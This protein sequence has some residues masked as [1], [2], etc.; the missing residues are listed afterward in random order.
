MCT[1][2]KVKAKKEKKNID[3]NKLLIKNKA[4]KMISIGV[5]VVLVSIILTNVI[6]VD[7]LYK[8]IGIMILASFGS[9]VFIAGI[10]SINLEFFG[11]IDYAEKRFKNII[12]ED[13]YVQNLSR[14]KLEELQIKIEEQKLYGTNKP[15][16]GSFHSIVRNDIEPM[17]EEIFLKDHSVVIDCD[18]DGDLIKKD[19]HMTMSH[20]CLDICKNRNII[21]GESKC[22]CSLS[23]IDGLDDNKLFKLKSVK[24]NGLEMVNNVVVTIEE[25]DEEVYNRAVHLDISK[26]SE[27][28]F[29]SPEKENVFEIR[30]ST[31]VPLED[32]MVT[33]RVP[34]PAK[35][36][37][38][39][40]NYDDNVFRIRGEGFGFMDSHKNIPILESYKRSATIKFN[41]WILPGDGGLFLVEKL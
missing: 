9:A 16:E 19:I 8:N 34:F 27:A 11:Y 3:K 36:F 28:L 35:N 10:V 25:T 26:I 6:T 20:D 22:I 32:N 23:S 4:S 18:L 17:L 15:P 12:I 31:V 29:V 33:S 21:D 40:L 38:F 13:D 39:T 5:I 41:D 37:M 7:T 14:S 30:F 2:K 24:Y 1:R